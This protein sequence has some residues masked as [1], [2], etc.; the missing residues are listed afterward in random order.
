MDQK[1][2]IKPKTPSFFARFKGKPRRIILLSVGSLVTIVMFLVV[3]QYITKAGQRTPSKGHANSTAS[4]GHW[5]RDLILTDVNDVKYRALMAKE[6]IEKFQV[7]A[8]TFFKN[9]D[10]I[11]ESTKGKDL[12]GTKEVVDYF[13]IRWKDKLPKRLMIGMYRDTINRY[14]ATAE[15]F[16]NENNS[17]EPVPQAIFDEIDRIGSKAGDCWLLYQCHNK[18]LDALSRKIG[19]GPNADPRSIKAEVQRQ[20]DK[21]MLET[22]KTL[23]VKELE[24]V[25]PASLLPLGDHFAPRDKAPSKTSDKDI[26]HQKGRERLDEERSREE[27]DTLMRDSVRP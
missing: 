22:V 9:H 23:P 8:D 24:S 19:E 17:E 10:R 20:E 21:M 4:R 3:I 1:L 16:L 15:K 18:L 13:L 6:E 12:A 27:K 14:M 25:Q 11:L 26:Y 5:D 2:P 7:E